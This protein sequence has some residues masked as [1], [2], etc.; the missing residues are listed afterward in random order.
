MIKL[1]AFLAPR[2]S[3]MQAY[4]RF[5]YQI[6]IAPW[7]HFLIFLIVIAVVGALMPLGH[8][9]AISQ[10]IDTLSTNRNVAP[11]E[12]TV[13]V[14]ELLQPYLPWLLLLCAMILLE[15]IIYYEPFHQYLA[16][17]TNE[18]IREH[19]DA[20]FFK[21]VLAAPLK[22]FE[23]TTY[24]DQLKLARAMIDDNIA[25][26]L[27]QIQ[28]VV[29][30]LGSSFIIIGSLAAVH[31]A[32]LIPML[33][34]SF[35]LLQRHIRRARQVVAITD[36]QTTRQR[37]QLYWRN[38]LTQREYAAEVRLFGLS[39]HIIVSW[40]NITDQLLQE[41]AA[42]RQHGKRRDIGIALIT[43]GLNCSVLLG[44]ILAARADLL[45]IGTLLALIVLMQQYLDHLDRI[46][47]RLGR[48]QG[49]FRKLHNAGTFLA[50]KDDVVEGM[51]PAPRI[52][53]DGIRFTNVSFT[54][55]ESARP[56]LKDINVHIQ[57]GE[58]IAL[59][60]ENG[61][62]KSTF[63]R[64]LLGLYHPT[65]GHITIDGIDLKTIAP[66]S[67]CEKVSAV[68]QDFTRYAVTVREN[69]GFGRLAALGDVSSIRAAANQSGASEMIEQLPE[70]YETL[71][72]REFVGGHDLSG[73]QW[74]KL[75]IARAYLRDSAVLVLDEPASA[76]DA[77]AERD[78]YRQ[79]LDLSAGKTVVLIS[80]RLGSARLA[81]RIIFM[82]AGQ[83][84]EIGTHEELM[85]KRGYYA[86][87]YELQA[88]WYREQTGEET[89]Q[90]QLSR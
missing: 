48:L 52:T 58:R 39:Q 60:G 7:P 23:S 11:V 61:A 77:L 51:T 30:M 5:A 45:S 15:R 69:I 25:S 33:P 8:I 80:H 53:N 65:K 63:V 12:E 21:K 9:A 76:L 27:L 17:R 10:L 75:A 79:F 31:W 41:T 28:T 66:S 82:H 84:Q 86:T 90:Q 36:A 46:G 67:W 55:P 24:Y 88:V 34:G 72:G 18:H 44:L 16:A 87:L 26:R 3:A 49:F 73:G 68:M 32:L 22:Q 40:R 29:A 56:T 6:L 19:F 70:G 4:V 57:P 85:A 89:T 74:Q 42:V 62:G 50:L 14:L 81:D 83:I 43:V 35:L 71:L 64:L 13:S 2:L 47:L 38:L 54:Y 20:L 78:V 59:V 1:W 37:R